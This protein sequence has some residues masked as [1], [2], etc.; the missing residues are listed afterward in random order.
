MRASGAIYLTGRWYGDNAYDTAGNRALLK[1]E[2]KVPLFHT[3]AE[4]GDGPARPRSA[5]RKSR[6]RS[7]VESVF[8]I[9]VEN[10]TFGTLRV[11]GFKR[12]SIEVALAC[13]AWDF[14]FL[15]ATFVGKTECRIS[16]K[17]LLSGK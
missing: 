5:R 6:I 9:L 14:F 16:V 7:K 10:Y 3:K 2:V 4:S 15:M 8:G 11:R 17:Q 1:D 12:S 13:C